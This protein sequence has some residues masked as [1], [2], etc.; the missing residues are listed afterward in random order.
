MNGTPDPVPTAPVPQVAVGDTELIVSWADTA[1]AKAYAVEWALDGAFSQ[2][3]GRVEGVSS[4]Y[5]LA[6]LANGTPYWVRLTASNRAGT[7]TPSAAVSKTPVILVPATSVWSRDEGPFDSLVGADPP[8]YSRVLRTTVYSFTPGVASW[9]FR[10]T[11]TLYSDSSRTLLLARTTS[12]VP[13]R[14]GTITVDGTVATLSWTQ[15][16]ANGAWSGLSPSVAETW[17]MDVARTQLSSGSLLL[18]RN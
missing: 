17:T 16:W 5:H 14:Q 2:G 18:Q 6:G 4:P 3:E 12:S 15:E 11:T 8:L 1:Y 10:Q 7:S 9:T 13:F